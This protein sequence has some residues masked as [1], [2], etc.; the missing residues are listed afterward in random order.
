MRLALVLLAPILSGLLACSAV[1]FQPAECQSL[2]PDSQGMLFEWTYRDLLRGT[3]DSS[4]CFEF[5]GEVAQSIEGGYV[6]DTSDWGGSFP[7]DVFVH[8]EGD[9]RFVEGDLVV[10]IG[11]VAE[12]LT[13]ETILGV[14]RTIPAFYGSEMADMQ[15][16]NKQA[17]ATRQILAATQE[18][19][20]VTRQVEYRADYEARTAD[21][22]QEIQ[23]SCHDPID[24]TSQLH[25]ES[26]TADY[27][28]V[29][30]VNFDFAIGPDPDIFSVNTVPNILLEG[31]YT[32]KPLLKR[33]DTKYG[34]VTARWT[35]NDCEFKDIKLKEGPRPTPDPNVPQPT[36]TP[37]PAP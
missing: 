11:A 13:F 3:Y 31:H 28:Q 5:R 6:V 2:S 8:W 26:S 1:G 20:E 30:E 37:R 24:I 9:Y 7:G 15:Q 25:Y 27:Y 23:S 33:G 29:S 18:V 4:D 10:V 12:P 19:I 14:Q 32:M 34:R 21:A 36:Y 17:A 22:L 16:H 35:G